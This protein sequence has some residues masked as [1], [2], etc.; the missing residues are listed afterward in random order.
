MKK[1]VPQAL[2]KQF[3]HVEFFKEQCSNRCPFLYEGTEKLGGCAL[4]G[5]GLITNPAFCTRCRECIEEFGGVK[6]Q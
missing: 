1:S 2:L 6:K 5:W 4:F 3:Y